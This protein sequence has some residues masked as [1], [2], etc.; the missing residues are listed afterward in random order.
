MFVELRDLTEF[1]YGSGGRAVMECG[2]LISGY[3]TEENDVLFPQ[4]PMA[5]HNPSVRV[6]NT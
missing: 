2:P 4:H 6:G 5:V 1:N 3:N